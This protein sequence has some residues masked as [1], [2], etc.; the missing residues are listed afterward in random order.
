MSFIDWFSEEGKRLYGD[1]LPSLQE[2]KRM[3]IMKEPVGVAALITPVRIS[4]INY[5]I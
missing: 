3:F 4:L 1:V 5:C 2:D